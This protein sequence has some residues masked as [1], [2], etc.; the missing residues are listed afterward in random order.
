[1]VVIR[2]SILTRSDFDSISE[3]DRETLAGSVHTLIT[4]DAVSNSS[5]VV[6]K[7]TRVRTIPGPPLTGQKLDNATGILTTFT[8]T[9]VGTGTTIGAANT[10][11]TP[12]SEQVDNSITT[13]IPSS[14]LAAFNLPMPD[15]TD[16]PLPT[17]LTALDVTWNEGTGDGNYTESAS[18]ES[19]GTSVSLSLSCNGSGQGSAHV[20]PDI[21]PTFAPD[22]GMHVPI[23]DWFFY[24]PHP[25]TD[26][27]VLAKL[28][29]LSY[30]ITP[31]TSI[32]AG[33]CSDAT[34]T[35]SADEPFQFK[36]LVGASGANLA[37]NTTYYAR[38][39]VAGVSFKYSLTVGGAAVTTGSAS[40]GTMTPVFSAWPNFRPVEVYF[41]IKSQKVSLAFKAAA[42][43]S[44]FISGSDYSHGESTGNG[45]DTDY[46]ATVESKSIRPTIH[47]AI[48]LGGSTTKSKKCSAYAIAA[49]AAATNF[50]GA[51]A[52]DGGDAYAD[53]SVTP[54]SIPATPVA[55][56]PTAGKYLQKIDMQLS[57][58]PGYAVIRARVV[59]FAKV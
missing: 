39:I 52:G 33:V 19:V 49:I 20:M 57:Q 34:H 59:D 4:S 15:Y 21:I 2:S 22:R 42:R 14:A 28:A 48:S 3:A 46:S 7:I 40:S 50:P 6:L 56:I 51:G 12:I 10:E 5:L 24:L 23:I 32:V 55:S 9:K 44:V 45:Y 54:T 30:V 36:T 27:A 41:T 26:A 53:A 58:W 1:M 37:I 11:V 17:V 8:E 16:I 38:D 31:V 18:G 47:E 13:V 29:T 35:L 43:C 25:V